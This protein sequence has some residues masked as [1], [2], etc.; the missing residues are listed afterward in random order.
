MAKNKQSKNNTVRIVNS[1]SSSVEIDTSKNLF[2]TSAYEHNVVSEVSCEC[3]KKSSDCNEEF[4]KCNFEIASKEE[5]KRR[6]FINYMTLKHKHEQHED[7]AVRSLPVI[8]N[9]L[10]TAYLDKYKGSAYD[11]F[12][13]MVDHDVCIECDGAGTLVGATIEKCTRCN[14]TGI[15]ETKIADGY[16]IIYMVYTYQ[17]LLHVTYK[18]LERTFRVITITDTLEKA[19]QFKED[20][21]EDIGRDYS[22]NI[23][24]GRMV[25]PTKFKEYNLNSY[26]DEFV[27]YDTSTRQI[28]IIDDWVAIHAAVGVGPYTDIATAFKGRLIV[29]PCTKFYEQYETVSVNQLDSLYQHTFRDIVHTYLPYDSYDGATNLFNL[30]IHKFTTFT[31]IMENIVS[32]T[33][34]D[35]NYVL[36]GNKK[37]I[38]IVNKIIDDFRLFNVDIDKA[39]AAN[40][41]H[42]VSQLCP[43]SALVSLSEFNAVAV[44]LVEYILISA[45]YDVLT[46]DDG[47][48]TIN[49]SSENNSEKK[50]SE[51]KGSSKTIKRISNSCEAQYM[52]D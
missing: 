45:E 21:H 17:H 34:T 41:I 28:F 13:M 52:D 20:M 19:E 10:C 7:D 23:G 50:K 31:D 49:P 8:L 15:E 36:D 40:V 44:F 27:L 30:Y 33:N 29:L 35:K 32:H 12:D 4:G 47:S 6:L 39:S 18:D 24:I 9:A 1:E 25:V 16:S 14:G 26:G 48:Y 38:E 2:I 22:N 42:C 46:S 11:I 43:D 51:P 5:I 37:T 3:C